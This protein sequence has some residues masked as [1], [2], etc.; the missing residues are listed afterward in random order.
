MTKISKIFDT[1]FKDK[2]SFDDL[3]KACYA[4]HFKS[5]D[6]IHAH[7]FYENL[8]SLDLNFASDSPKFANERCEW[9]GLNRDQIRWND[10]DPRCK[11]R[12]KTANRSIAEVLNDEETTFFALLERGKDTIPQL[13]NRKYNGIVTAESLFFCQTTLGYEPDIVSG[14]MDIDIEP[15]MA[16]YERLMNIHRSKS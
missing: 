4:Y 14:I 16:E 8:K 12:P 13:I 15:M 9:C 6:D 1:Y 10:D 2:P 11:N 3:E 7:S 5:R